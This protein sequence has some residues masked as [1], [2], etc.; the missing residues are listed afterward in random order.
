MS[1]KVTITYT[2]T[3]DLRKGKIADEY[4]EQLGDYNDTQRQRRWFAIDRFIGHDNIQLFDRR[5]KL[6]VKEK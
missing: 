4:K 1:K 3:Y 2:V 5:A 6:T